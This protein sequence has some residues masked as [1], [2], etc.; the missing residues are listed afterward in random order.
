MV[1]EPLGATREFNVSL[2]RL[3]FAGPK[4]SAVWKPLLSA[5]LV[6]AGWFACAF[7]PVWN[8]PGLGAGFVALVVAVHLLL[9]PQRAAFVRWLAFAAAWG[10]VVDSLQAARGVLLFHEPLVG[11]FVCP[12]W[13]TALWVNFA[14]VWPLTLSWLAPRPTLAATLGLFAGPASYYGGAALGALALGQPVERS[15]PLIGL[16]WAASMAVWCRVATQI[17]LFGAGP[18]GSDARGSGN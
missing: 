16:A 12:L 18:G 10:T 6:Q 13:F 7:E 14:C 3:F 4:V 17:H 2:R 8:R 5:V 9:V 11:G 15:L 1:T